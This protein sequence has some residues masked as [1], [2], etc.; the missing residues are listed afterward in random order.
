MAHQSRLAR[1]V[2]E[3]CIAVSQAD[4][5]L[6]PSEVEQVRVVR[7]ALGLESDPGNA[8]AQLGRRVPLRLPVASAALPGRFHQWDTQS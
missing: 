5:R 1:M 7:Q 2:L 4:D 6:H 8:P 3:A